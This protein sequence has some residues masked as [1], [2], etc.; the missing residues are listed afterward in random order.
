MRIT[1]KKLADEPVLNRIMETMK[2]KGVTQQDVL[3]YLGLANSA[4]TRWKYDNGTSYMKYL[5]RIADYLCVPRTYLLKGIYEVANYED[6]SQK[7]QKLVETF[8]ELEKA[9]QDMFLRQ[10]IG[11]RMTS[12]GTMKV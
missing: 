4:F 9:E 5:G 1:T 12:E 6:L 8:R 2:E 10:I 7:E 11:F 3:Q